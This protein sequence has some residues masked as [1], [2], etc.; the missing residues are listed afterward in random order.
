VLSLM[1]WNRSAPLTARLVASTLLS[2]PR[3][4]SLV[5]R[6]RQSTNPVRVGHATA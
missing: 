5:E 3:R 2:P 1:P 4:G 6:V